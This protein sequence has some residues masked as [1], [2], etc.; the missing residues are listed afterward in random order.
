MRQ[1]VNERNKVKLARHKKPIF[2]AI[3]AVFFLLLIYYIRGGSASS[4]YDP[5][6]PLSGLKSTVATTGDTHFYAAMLDAGSTGSRIHVYE[7]SKA[8]NGRY[9]L[10]QSRKK[11]TVSL[12]LLNML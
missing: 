6:S 10:R 8:T 5:D 7:F 11:Y 4:N 1:R 2:M 12:S 3:G 9:K